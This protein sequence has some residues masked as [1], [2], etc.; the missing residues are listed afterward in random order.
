MRRFCFTFWWQLF[1]S[2][3]PG[4]EFENSAVCATQMR[5]PNCSLLSNIWIQKNGLT[6]LI[7]SSLEKMIVRDAIWKF[8][9]FYFELT[10]THSLFNEE[11]K[12]KGTKV[13]WSILLIKLILM[14]KESDKWVVWNSLRSESAEKS[15]RTTLYIIGYVCVYRV[16][17]Q[18][19]VHGL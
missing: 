13:D 18:Y 8:L 7:Q 12:T 10:D 6:L 3:Y 9:H 1:S 15:E 14:G 2:S 11:K 4:N 19:W 17:E 5:W 16:C